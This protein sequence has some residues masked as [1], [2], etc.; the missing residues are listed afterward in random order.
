MR[1]F[2]IEPDQITDDHVVHLDREESL[3]ITKVLRLHP[4]LAIELYDGT[5]FLY[6]A[7]I[8]EVGKTES[9][10]IQSKQ[11]F[12]RTQPTIILHTGLL[13]NK[14]MK[15]VLQKATELGVDEVQLLTSDNT[16]VAVPDPKKMLRYQK[17]IQESCKQ[18]ERLHP[19]AIFGPTPLAEHI[20]ATQ[21]TGQRYFFWERE[22]LQDPSIIA[23]LDPTK[24][25]H[26][27]TGPEG[28][29][30]DQE[31]HSLPADIKTIS[32]GPQIL[33]AE[34]AVIAGVAIVAF[35]SGRF[36]F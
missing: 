4:G 25:I 14:K 33:R 28:G 1:R 27:F 11:Y 30:S 31:I 34:T 17:I 8:T 13:K 20:L 26:L 16:C 29:F 7:T 21:D 36:K 3:H 19:M 6:Q 9:V 15:L 35:L 12:D 5:G 18:C 22:Q 32:L 10:H 2:F 23:A 24:P